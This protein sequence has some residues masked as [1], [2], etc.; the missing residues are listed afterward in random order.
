L[1]R[2]LMKLAALGTATMAAPALANAEGERALTATRIPIASPS[3]ASSST[4]EIHGGGSPLV[5]LHG[6]V[7]AADFFGDTL[8]TSFGGSQANT[9]QEMAQHHRVYAVHLRGHGFS[10]DKDEPWSYEVMADDVAALMG[11]I[12][13]ESAD[14]MG[15]SLGGGVGL[16]VAIRHPE[17]VRKLVVISMAFRADGDYPEIRAAFD[18]MPAEAPATAEF[19]KSSPLATMYPDVDW[20]VMMR[21]TGEMNQPLHDW[22]E[23]GRRDHIAGA[24]HVHRCRNNP[25]R[26]HGGVLQ[27]AWRRTAR[28]RDGRL[29]ALGQPAGDNPQPHAPQ[30]RDLAGGGDVRE[31]VFVSGVRVCR[32]LNDGSYAVNESAGVAISTGPSL[33]MR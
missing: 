11:E 6:G 16:Q 13:L 23:G 21:K 9:V 28:R 4:Y 3:T 10:K 27:A 8:Q 18:T 2:M 1:R 14:V 25:A 12:G 32:R 15:W 29:R 33:E 26:P 7:N 30:Q 31:G 22:S 17:R 19:L 20:E 24:D 5:M